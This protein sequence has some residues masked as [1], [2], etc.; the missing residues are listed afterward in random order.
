MR[1]VRVEERKGVSTMEGS[2]ER[3]GRGRGKRAGRG[4]GRGSDEVSP[5]PYCNITLI[6]MR[7]GEVW[8]G[9]VWRGV[10]L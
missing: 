7:R 5:S 1:L 10:T 4:R 8:F 9:L 3:G 6:I 2:P